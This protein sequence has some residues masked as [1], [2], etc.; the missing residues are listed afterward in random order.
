MMHKMFSCNGRFINVFVLL[1]W[2]KFESHTRESV[3]IT[4]KK[5]ATLEIEDADTENED[6]DD[7]EIKTLPKSKTKKRK[8]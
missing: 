8:G 6:K 1:R 2:I 4:N 7:C 3:L 5:G